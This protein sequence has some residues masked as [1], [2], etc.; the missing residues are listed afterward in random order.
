MEEIY[1]DNA[2]TSFP[3]PKG[4]I[5]AMERYFDEVASSPGRGGYRRAQRA[6]RILDE[7]RALTAQILGVEEPKKIHFC[8]NATHGLNLVIQGFLKPGDRVVTTSFEHNSVIRPLHK[9]SRE[10][11]IEL[12]VVASDPDGL[13]D[14]REFERRITPATRLV[15][16]NHASNV[17]GIR[18]P[19][20]EI[21]SIA[22][23][24]GAKVLVDGSQTA[25]VLDLA[26]MKLEADFF[27]ATGHKGLRGPSGTGFVY[28]SDPGEIEPVMVGG[29]GANSISFFQ[30][31]NPREKF[32]AGTCNYL[33]IAG[34]HAALRDVLDHPCDLGEEL[35]LA[36]YCV[37][38]LARFPFVKL[39]GTND[40]DHKIP[41]VAFNLQGKMP[42]EVG[43]ALDSRFGIMTRTGLHC[44]PIL[45][46][47]I[48]TFPH[49][50]V[51]VSL[52]PENKR[53]EVDRLIEAVEAIGSH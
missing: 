9:L 6:A 23:Q 34:L 15:V 19:V 42:Q 49:G 47:T 16:V 20:R 7:T 31:E 24:V 32:E 40:L 46:Q 37:R 36:E 3:K 44:A 21:I 10:R 4:I 41:I 39:Y 2:S 11:G 33:G 12:D 14:L 26:R 17:I 35:R 30:P 45:H 28:I 22:H 25:G 50:C 38:E 13:F 29:T 5:R 43:E 8:I 51:R 53:R 18:T 48:G 52:G 1:F 27:V